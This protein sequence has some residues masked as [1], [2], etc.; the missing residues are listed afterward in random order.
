[1]DEFNY[2]EMLKTVPIK[3]GMTVDV[4]SD[5]F[6]V[7]SQCHKQ[8]LE[9]RPDAF[10][11]ALCH[12]VGPEGTVLI[13]TFSWDFCH[14]KG[15]DMKKTGSRVGALGNIAL[16]RRDFQRTKHPIYSWMVWG[17]NQDLFCGFNNIESFG[18][19]SIFA[20]EAASD[21]AVQINLG[22]PDSIGLTLLHCVEYKVGVPYRYVKNFTDTYVDTNGI[23]TERTY[24]MY[25]R[26]LD[27]DT[28]IHVDIYFPAL[29]AQG[30]KLRS[31][32]MGIPIDFFRLKPL[33][34]MYE[35]DIRENGVP[36]AVSMEKLS[37]KL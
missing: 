2:D 30:A 28:A 26:N 24:S 31:T 18:A 12:A 23:A 14:G 36:K 3:P 5:L 19:D 37:N 16:K 29:E 21:N 13:R 6:T 20:W 25:V 4:A 34:Q 17:K 32:Y 7:I 33:C 15:F 22:D 1:M 10:I 35:N 8:N 27:Y 11:D 9:F